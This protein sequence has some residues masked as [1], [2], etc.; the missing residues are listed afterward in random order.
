MVIDSWAYH[1]RPWLAGEFRRE[2]HSLLQS[3]Y[4]VASLESSDEY[5]LFKLVAG[6]T[7]YQQSLPKRERLAGEFRK[8][9]VRMVYGMNAV[10]SQESSHVLTR[11]DKVWR[12]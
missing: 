2:A 1:S 8:E 3:I 9:S 4:V 6:S 10:S 5:S 11:L 7:C 12:R